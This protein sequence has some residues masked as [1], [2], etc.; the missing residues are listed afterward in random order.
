MSQYN[1][2]N[3]SSPLPGSVFVDTHLE[4]WRDALHSMHKGPTRP[5]YAIAGTMWI[6]DATTPWLLKVFNGTANDITLGKIDATT[7]TFEPTGTA[8]WGGSSGGTAN[9]LTITPTI[10]LTAYAAGVAYEFLV[11]ASNTSEAPTIA[12][13]GLSAQ[14]IK[15]STGGAKVN[16]PKGGLQN[17][18]IARIVHD[19]TD[20]QLINLRPTNKSANIASAGTL[21]LDNASGD[22]VHVTGTTTVTAITLM[23]GRE[24]TVIADGAFLITD[25]SGS[26]PQ[27]I[28]CPGAG[29]FTTVAGDIFKVR[30]E[31]NGTVRIHSVTNA[32]EIAKSDKLNALGSVSGGTT[33]DLKSGR[34]V[35]VTIGGATTFTFSNPKATGSLDGFT[36]DITNAGTQITWPASVKWPAGTQPTW[37]AS[38]SSPQGRDRALFI[39]TDGGTTWDGF[40]L[41]KGMA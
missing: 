21:V 29:S 20:F 35:S 3:L 12:I 17:G 34:A 32:N 2:G 22:Y 14:T 11:T 15:C 5:S 33:V 36:M 30:G 39:T 38:G 23:E 27:G 13:S 1:F 37:S 41:G 26:S 31:G 25:S 28:V 10:P 4:P 16:L 19:G 9:A 8:K 7:F 40:Q 18:M 6:D 24:I